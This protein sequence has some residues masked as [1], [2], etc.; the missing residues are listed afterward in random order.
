[1]TP[2]RAAVAALAGVSIDLVRSVT[3]NAVRQIYGDRAPADVVEVACSGVGETGEP[4]YYWQVGN[5]CYLDDATF[6]DVVAIDDLRYSQT[7]GLSMMAGRK[8][9][10]RPGPEPE[11]NSHD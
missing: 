4:C 10:T 2:R 3:A 9:N 6:G 11:E 8:N 1:M 5:T 7:F